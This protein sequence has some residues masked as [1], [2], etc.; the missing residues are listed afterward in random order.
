MAVLRITGLPGDA[1]AAAAGFHIE[2]LPKIT[3]LRED[4]V[5]IFPSAD[6]THR[7]WRLAA[8]QSLARQFAPVRINAVA[9]DDEAAIV[10]A[11]RYLNEAEGVTGQ[12]LTLDSAG[13]GEVIGSL[14]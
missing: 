4:T 14:P 3:P 13:A 5:L 2:W 9:G 10:A 6:H 8:T 7:A 1:L 12:Y 11:I